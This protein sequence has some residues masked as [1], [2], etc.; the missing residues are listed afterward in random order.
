MSIYTQSH[1]HVHTQSLTHTYRH[2]YTFYTFTHTY[3][4]THA[5]MHTLHNINHNPYVRTSSIPFN[6]STA[7]STREKTPVPMI[8]SLVSPPFNTDG[9]RSAVEYECKSKRESVC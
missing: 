9:A 2:R 6:S 5:H 4:H 7:P 1:T 8:H 3:I